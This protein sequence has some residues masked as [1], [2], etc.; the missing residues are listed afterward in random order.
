[1][2]VKGFNP[3]FNKDSNI[4]ILGSFPSVKSRQ[5]DF[6]YGNTQNRFWKMISQIF[7][8]SLNSTQQKIDFLL[9]NNI[10][11]WDIVTECEIE[12]SMDK[13]VKNPI[14]ANLKMVLPPNTKVNKILCN[15]K[16]SYNLTCE[17]CAKN[18]IDI[19]VIYLQ[20]TSPANPRF[21]LLEW[22][23]ELKK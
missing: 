8:V 22:E 6:Y 13:D 16:L 21:N 4:L 3:V 14:F 7:N 11:L 12:G 19:P 10:A 18:N 20:S 9:S 1:M 17:F 5:I 23:T 15:G 2:K